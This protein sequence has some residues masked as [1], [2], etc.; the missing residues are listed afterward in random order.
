MNIE[1]VL[2]ATT[3]WTR[4]S[5]ERHPRP[6]RSAVSAGEFERRVRVS[7][8]AVI[9]S[10]VGAVDWW[11][12]RPQGGLMARPRTRCRLCGMSTKSPHGLFIHDLRIHRRH[13]WNSQGLYSQR[14]EGE[15]DGVTTERAGGRR[16]IRKERPMSAAA[17]D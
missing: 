8:H 14:K 4:I 6:G 2:A 12:N 1:L 15:E 13:N 10:I 11:P 16:A 17:S 3:G 5:E 9:H 7:A